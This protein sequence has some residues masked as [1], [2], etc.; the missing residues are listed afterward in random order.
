MEILSLIIIVALFV[1]TFLW[2]LK[3]FL[4]PNIDE[5]VT[6]SMVDVKLAELEYRRQATYAAIKDLELDYESGKIT[7]AGY[8]QTRLQLVHQA[9]ET[10]KQIEAASDAVGLQLDEEI[11]ALLSQIQPNRFGKA[12]KEKAKSQIRGDAVEPAAETCPNCQAVVN[13][14]DAFCSGCGATLGNRCP[15]CHELAAPGDTFCTHCGT[16]LL[17]VAQ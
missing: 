2:V 7:E 15:T 1:G 12:V 9:A 6:G 4:S 10:L 11:D 14:G 13:T 5:A 16:R 17:E 8:R 3:P